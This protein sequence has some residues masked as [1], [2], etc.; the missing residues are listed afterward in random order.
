MPPIFKHLPLILCLFTFS[1]LSCPLGPNIE[2][3]S[4]LVV[5]P[6]IFSFI[7]HTLWWAFIHAKK[8]LTNITE[9]STLQ[10][11]EMT[12]R[13]YL[14]SVLHSMFWHFICLKVPPLMPSFSLHD[15]LTIPS[16]DPLLCNP[17]LFSFVILSWLPHPSLQ[18]QL[19]S[20]YRWLSKLTP[21]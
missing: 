3:M 14:I 21:S 11:P 7:L 1:S 6:D 9:S 2:K 17:L 16:W 20:I 13:L 19:L 10:D 4:S 8:A 5:F 18:C 15:S 12:L